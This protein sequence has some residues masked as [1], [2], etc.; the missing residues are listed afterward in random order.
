MEQCS[1]RPPVRLIRNRCLSHWG[2]MRQLRD[3][4][5]LWPYGP[6]LGRAPRVNPDLRNIDCA[7]DSASV[8][9]KQLRFRGRS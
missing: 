7:L 5:E 6:H 9:A 8:V 2:W 4:A 1:S 3:F